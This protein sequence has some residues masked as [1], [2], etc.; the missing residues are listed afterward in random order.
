M[1]RAGITINQRGQLQDIQVYAE[2][3]HGFLGDLA[4][5]VIAP[6]GQTVLL[7][8]RTLG[9]QTHLRKTYT[10]ENTPALS[11]LL[12]QIVNGRWQLQVIDYT[13]THQGQ[14]LQWSVKLGI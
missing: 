3:T 6:Q 8:G 7:Q 5:S 12:N 13:E 2:I 1:Q 9:R 11:L 4:I 14:L 10:F